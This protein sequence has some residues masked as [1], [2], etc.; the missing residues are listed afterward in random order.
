MLRE[1]VHEVLRPLSGQF[2]GVRFLVIDDSAGADIEVGELA[3]FTDVEVLTPTY[4]LGHQHAIV[5]GVRTLAQRIED[6][7]IVVTLDS[8]GEDRPDDLPAL[9]AA[10][11]NAE[12]VKTIVVARRTQRQVGLA[13]R[14]AYAVFRIL[15]RVLT[16]LVVDSGNFAAYYG[17]TAKRV[18]FHPNFDVCYS[19]SLLSLGLPVVK[20]PCPRGPRYEGRSRMTPATLVLHGLRMMMPFL[21]RITVRALFTFGTLFLIGLV[22]ALAVAVGAIFEVGI[23]TEAAIFAPAFAGVALVGFGN[24]VV[25]FALFT[26]YG[27]LRL[28]PSL[29]LPPGGDGPDA[30]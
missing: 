10:L 16:G 24:F 6:H 4:G 22:L 17:W 3:K 7:D 15:F 23:P 19:S 13:F 2:S 20:V 30:R 9:L 8:D 28:G 14:A 27:G 1:R 11:R 18:L 29:A 26:N 21:D 5:L 25:L 12:A